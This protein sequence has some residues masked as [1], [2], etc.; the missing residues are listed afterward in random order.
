MAPDDPVVPD[1]HVGDRARTRPAA[2]DGGP[3]GH[4]DPC[5]PHGPDSHGDPGGPGGPAAEFHAFFERH[6][7]QLSRLAYLLT[8]DHDAADDITA[9]AFT[10]AWR[11]WDR[12][13]QADSPLA[14]LRRTVANMAASRLR[15]I[16]RERHGLGIL[17]SL[18]ETRSTDTDVPAV[19]DVRTALMS[20]AAGKRE[21]L[22][23]RYAFD[24]SEDET[25]R[26][27]GISV[28]TVKSQTS[29]GAGELERIL[30]AGTRDN[31]RGS[32]R[33]PQAPPAADPVARLGRKHPEARKGLPRRRRDVDPRARLRGGEAT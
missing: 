28:G 23:L 1:G 18:A 20:L 16:M 21:C 33:G 9:D 29:K 31:A 14:Y 17:G 19:V 3:D 8:N 5:T 27:L 11:R 6:H 10:A 7:R 30:L 26:T 24:L 13:R 22:V 12:V 15:R 4:D 2:V 25:A 32:A